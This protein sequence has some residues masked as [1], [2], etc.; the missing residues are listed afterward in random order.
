MYPSEAKMNCS[1]ELRI[2]QPVNLFYNYSLQIVNMYLCVLLSL[3]L[4]S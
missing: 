3:N 1:V 2:N 4:I